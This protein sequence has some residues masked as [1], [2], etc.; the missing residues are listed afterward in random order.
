MKIVKRNMNLFKEEFVLENLNELKAIDICEELNKA[1]E[2]D[3][4]YYMV[5]LDDYVVYNLK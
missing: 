1:N 2:E 5:V 4:V 3:G